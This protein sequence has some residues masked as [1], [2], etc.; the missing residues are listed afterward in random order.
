MDFGV[1]GGGA[2][3]RGASRG[4]SEGTVQMSYWLEGLGLDLGV[5][6][7]CRAAGDSKGPR[8]RGRTG[9]WLGRR[10]G[11]GGQA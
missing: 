6:W 2:W 3:A 7:P 4:T 9:A 1:G 8:R 10:P 11:V 5:P